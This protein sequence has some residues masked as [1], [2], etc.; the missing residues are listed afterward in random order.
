[1]RAQKAR[2]NH[3][4]LLKASAEEA[5]AKKKQDRIDKIEAERAELRE[6]HLQDEAAFNEAARWLQEKYRDVDTSH[7]NLQVPPQTKTK[8]KDTLLTTYEQEKENSVEAV[9]ENGSVPWRHRPQ[10][11]VL[12]PPGGESSIQLGTWKASPPTK[13]LPL[14]HYTSS[15]TRL[16]KPAEA[17]GTLK[18]RATANQKEGP[19]VSTDSSFDDKVDVRDAELSPSSPS[20]LFNLNDIMG[21]SFRRDQ[22][23][24]G[25]LFNLQKV[26][27]FT[28]NCSQRSMQGESYSPPISYSMETAVVS[29]IL[30]HCRLIDAATVQLYLSQLS[31][32]RV[33]AGV[34]DYLL[35]AR[36]DL[37]HGFLKHVHESPHINWRNQALLRAAWEHER[38][39]CRPRFS[40]E[41][42]ESF[43]FCIG[44]S[45]QASNVS[46]EHRLVLDFLATEFSVEW[47]LNALLSA[48]VLEGFYTIHRYLLGLKETI[49]VY[50]NVWLCMKKSTHAVGDILRWHEIRHFLSNYHS[51][52]STHVLSE[53]WPELIGKT[54]KCVASPRELKQLLK[55]FLTSA[56][57]TCF[58]DDGST[59]LADCMRK[60]FAAVH[61]ICNEFHESTSHERP[62]R[63]WTQFNRTR[64]FLM[65]AL[66]SHSVSSPDASA[67]RELL[68]RL[69]YNNYY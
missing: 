22:S 34:K 10:I 57:K 52:V 29:P 20:K 65:K 68:M 39:L 31:Y 18:P 59:T 28:S 23:L 55:D 24:I 69:N 12:R 2:E 32:L 61:R 38:R 14:E 4:A 51:Y 36:G 45:P 33:L 13:R 30:D 15:A 17:K 16:V 58:L 11:A 26:Q 56:Q 6:K 54:E 40:D 25:Q 67:S 63:S 7:L 66:K 43:S 62:D 19:E 3:L 8:S 21:S 5:R 48:S 35:L 37:F 9:A 47:P 49:I 41:E 64:K 1:M 50:E 42:E 27:V 46:H 60:L 53:L 44:V